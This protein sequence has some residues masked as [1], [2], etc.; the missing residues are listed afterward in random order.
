MS[1]SEFTHR[2]YAFFVK[3]SERLATL[4]GLGGPE[5]ST[6]ESARSNAPSG[7]LDK[8]RNISDDQWIDFSS[9]D[10]NGPRDQVVDSAERTAYAKRSSDLNA[11]PPES[12]PEP[13]PEWTGTDEISGSSVKKRRYRLQRTDP[14]PGEGL[15]PRSAA[16]PTG[17][18][19]V[20]EISDR[21]SSSM[22]PHRERA[23][24]DIYET[25]APLK[26]ITRP[27]ES[28]PRRPDTF[29]TRP[30]GSAERLNTQDQTRHSES[31][32]GHIAMHFPV[33]SE[34]PRKTHF[35]KN[36]DVNPV[37]ETGMKPENDPRRPND[38]SAEFSFGSARW[39]DLPVLNLSNERE[40]FGPSRKDLEH[41]LRLEREQSG[42][43]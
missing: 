39:I 11:L 15:R 41:L 8:V 6:T 32:H 30:S 29:H 13:K 42:K 28:S 16:A 4:L 21:V 2:F 43:I 34:T 1:L 26:K 9:E 24:E 12:S 20:K 36:L 33:R 40:V 22:T 31:S 5:P 23:F 25:A 37:V 18:A 17:Q 14:G 10:V 38:R 7:W 3:R 27:G 19:S 35:P